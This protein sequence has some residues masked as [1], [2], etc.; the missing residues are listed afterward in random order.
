MSVLWACPLDLNAVYACDERGRCQEGFTCRDEVCEPIVDAG[1]AG[2]GMGGDAGGTAGAGTGG[3]ATGGGG[4]AGGDVGGGS[5]GGTCRPSAGTCIRDVDCGYVDAGCGV[6]VFCGRCVAPQECGVTTPNRCAE[7]RVCTPEGWCWEHPLP[8]GGDLLTAFALGPRAVWLGTGS[9]SLL[10]WNGE[11][12]QGTRFPTLAGIGIKAIFGGSGDDLYVGAEGGR[13]FRFDGVAWTR[14]IISTPLLDIFCIHRGSSSVPVAGGFGA[15]LRRSPDA[16]SWTPLTISPTASPNFRRV[17]VAEPFVFAV[18]EAGAVYRGV[19]QSG[20]VTLL[21]PAPAALTGEA[22][23]AFSNDGG[24]LAVGGWDAGMAQVLLLDLKEPMPEWRAVASYPA[25]GPVSAMAVDGARV[26]VA[27]EAG[28]IA[29]VTLDGGVEMPVPVTSPAWRAVTVLGQ[30]EV[31]LAGRGGVMGFLG[32]DGGSWQLATTSFSGNRHEAL[33]DGCA[34]AGSIAG[35]PVAHVTGVGNSVATRETRWTWASGG[36]QQA[37]FDWVAC[38]VTEPG[39]AWVIGNDRGQGART[40]RVLTRSG[41]SWTSADPGTYSENWLSVSGLADG[42]TYFLANGS[43]IVVNRDGGTRPDAFQA[44]TLDGGPVNDLVA[45]DNGGSEAI[46]GAADAGVL[47]S[48]NSRLSEFTW[49]PTMLSPFGLLAIH[50]V[51]SSSQPFFTLAVGAR[52]FFVESR[53]NGRSPGRFGVADLTDVWV[54]RSHVGYIATIDAGTTVGRTS[55]TVMIRFADGGVRTEPVPVD[56]RI[57]G[58]F[59]VDDLGDVTRVWVTGPGG[60][61]LRRDFLPDAG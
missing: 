52:G 6:A 35:N 5:A 32:L 15:L 40:S 17:F 45:I 10:F 44:V 41:T 1:D 12:T 38:H 47:F 27:G 60:A 49:R 50:G 14:E 29:V 25:S 48:S 34:V 53:P 16:G 3:G 7:P 43:V 30:D 39:R 59:G 51:A 54:S 18:T 56:Q 9:G 57:R 20:M 4:S 42:T 2:G 13:I 23:A 19:L 37:G 11:H 58:L 31:L 8:H 33:N 22:Q 26:Y 61:I 21:V 55:P 24:F 28:S 46:Q 36:A